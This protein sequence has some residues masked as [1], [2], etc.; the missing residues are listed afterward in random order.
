MQVR[1]NRKLKNASRFNHLVPRPLGR[2]EV[3]KKN[4]TV[5]DTIELIPAVVKQSLPQAKR[6]AKQLEGRTL[7]ETC[8]NIWQWIVDH[9]EYE[10]DKPNREQVRTFSRM[11]WDRKGDCDCYSTAISAMLHHVHGGVKHALRITKYDHKPYFQHIYVVV[12]E[13]GQLGEPGSTYITIDPVVDSFD[14]EVPF[15][16]NKDIVM[17]LETLSG[18]DDQ[19]VD[20]SVV[21][22]DYADAM[23]GN[24]T[25]HSLGAL[26]AD[27]INRIKAQWPI[28]PGAPAL[29]GDMR[30]KKYI[31]IALKAKEKGMTWQEYQQWSR[32]DFTKRTGM[33]PEQHSAHVKQQIAEGQARGRE[34]Q[35]KQADLFRKALQQKG[36]YYPPNAT[37]EELRQIF[38]DNPEPKK[39]AKVLNAINRFN[40]GVAP[41]RAG[42]LLAMKINMF[43]IP[44]RVRWAMIP[45]NVAVAHGIPA[46]TYRKLKDAYTKL[47]KVFFG[48]GGKAINLRKS[49]IT[50]K[51][52]K[53][54]MVKI[55]GIERKNDGVHGLGQVNLQTTSM[56]QILGDELY[57][58]EGFN[59]LDPQQMD[60]SLSG[61]GTSTLGAI[62]AAVV[63]AA[64]TAALT[65]VAAIVNKAG[66]VNPQKPGL[67]KAANVLN[68]AAQGAA[69][70]SSQIPEDA[71]FKDLAQNIKTDPGA[72]L[73]NASQQ[74]QQ[75]SQGT[76]ETPG[77]MMNP[78]LLEQSDGSF[79]A[80]PGTQTMIDTNDTPEKP[81][82][83]LW[84]KLKK[85][86]WV[87]PL[88][89]IPVAGGIWWWASKSKATK[90]K[91]VG[92]TPKRKPQKPKNLLGKGKATGK[93]KILP[94][95]LL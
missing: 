44:E 66:K 61:L 36:I 81:Q 47:E 51:G 34:E 38:K 76:A 41:L 60:R 71:T 46:V 2:L 18:F 35:E 3:V 42:V 75:F 73:Q 5:D 50:G 70:I 90:S 68:V 15:T 43:K 26:S 52:N 9:I 31:A 55:P 63:V 27:E 83:T 16:E 64:A 14:Y 33:T 95:R 17:T 37:L 94:K 87:A 86:W 8:R 74:L 13:K 49:I 57:F 53:D 59:R 88:T 79:P 85:F 6:I 93:G 12:P 29:K 4:A 62:P 89:A 1:G 39:G 45:E 30:D 67:T 22:F 82:Q 25:G 58:D 78:A 72:F 77:K 48:A 21:S 80:I 28:V 84:Q 20:P 32:E 92:G 40:P 91:P 11:F 56:R 24:D 10:L 69:A 19:P 7:R 65:A 54:G 23:G